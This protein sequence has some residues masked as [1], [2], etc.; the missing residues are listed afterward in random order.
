MVSRVDLMKAMNRVL[1]EA[2]PDRTVY[3]N[4]APDDFVRPSF[5]IQYVSGTLDGDNFH[6]VE[7]TAYFTITI[8]E[9]VDE[10]T[11]SDQEA[12]LQT[13]DQV[14]RLFRAGYV[15]VGDRALKV[16]A[17]SGSIDEQESFVDLQFQFMDERDL[18][19]PEYHMMEQLHTTITEKGE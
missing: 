1:V 7:Q 12:L 2:F 9:S 16:I 6:L 13:H 10:Y 18:K 11:D 14:L 15:A 17:S 5:L 19:L 8:F 4:T 3:W